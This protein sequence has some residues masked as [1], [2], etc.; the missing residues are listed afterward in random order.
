MLPTLLELQAPLVAPGR[1]A[2]PIRR[3]P[4]DAKLALAVEATLGA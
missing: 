1:R 4:A 2:A 3:V